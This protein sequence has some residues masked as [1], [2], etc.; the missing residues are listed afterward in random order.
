MS[1]EQKTGEFKTSL[2]GGFRKADVLAYIEELTNKGQQEK[3]AQEAKQQ[4]LSKELEQLKADRIL[5]VEK[6]KEVCDKLAVQEKRTEQE[7]K[8]AQ[9]LEAQIAEL[10]EKANTYKSRMIVREQEAMNLKNDVQRLQQQIDSYKTQAELAQK[11]AEQEHLAGEELKRNLAQAYTA[12]QKSLRRDLLQEV[13]SREEQLLRQEQELDQKRT[14]QR[15]NMEQERRRLM[16]HTSHEQEKMKRSA[17][18]VA[19]TVQQLRQQ[20]AEVDRELNAAAQKLQQATITVYDA[21]GEAQNSLEHLDVQAQRFPETVPAMKKS[22][23]QQT[24]KKTAAKV[25]QS[26]KTMS[27]NLLELVER[28]LQKQKCVE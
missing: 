9:E 6:T 5:L 25:A 16:E 26:H 11:A 24:V 8:K 1:E 18:Q 12:K 7:K 21:L 10:E 2:V 15:Q 22:N 14:I 23:V 3:K 4:E 20:L 17:K 19:I 28:M 13:E 27:D